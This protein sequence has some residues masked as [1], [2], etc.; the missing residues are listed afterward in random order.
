MWQV[1]QLPQRQTIRQLLLT[2]Q[3]KRQFNQIQETTSDRAAAVEVEA[4]PE[5]TAKPEVAAKP[6]TATSAEVATNA[7][8]ATPTAEKV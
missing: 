5:T 7:G 8:L 4:K 2:N 3:L 1:L 6:E